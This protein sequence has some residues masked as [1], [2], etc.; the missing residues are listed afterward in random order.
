MSLL[1]RY[2]TPAERRRGC[3]WADRF[4]SVALVERN[5][6]AVTGAPT[7]SPDGVVL[8]GS[9]DYITYSLTGQE[10]D[11]AGVTIV[12]EFTP[13]FATD[14]NQFRYF[15]DTDVGKRYL[16]LKNNNAANNTLRVY[17]G[18]T[19]LTVIPEATY[20]PFWNV[21]SRNILVVS[22]TTGNSSVWLNGNLI[23]DADATAWTPD[24]PLTLHVGSDNAGAYRFDGTIHKIQ[25]YKSQLSDAECVDLSTDAVY[26]YRDTGTLV[27]PFGAAQHD[28]TN[29]RSLDLSGNGAHAVFGDGSTPT[30]YP[31]KIARHH[32]YD[33][34][35]GDYLVVPAT[36]LFNSNLLTIALEFWPDF[37]T[38]ENVIRRLFTT[39]SVAEHAVIKFDNGSANILQIKLGETII[40]NIAEATYAPFWR[41]GHRNLLTIAGDATNNLTNV[42]L[43]EGHILVDD[44]TAWAAIDPA[45]LYIGSSWA[46]STFFDGQITHFE[47]FPSLL[48]AMQREDFNIR[49]ARKINRV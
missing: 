47:V 15:C 23:L 49:L 25:I 4:T 9:S 28:P 18:N 7:F 8:D 16:I 40:E 37:E 24:E 2:S 29:V 20:S 35:G 30:T 33:F 5:G 1:Q 13:D 34:D 41:K 39:D 3:S 36:G 43:N 6:G 14:E 38:D 17:L 11:S 45:S 42:W 26:A 48:T 19:G 27:L 12:V 44:A 31:K 22:G 10:F 32:G 21:G 46:A